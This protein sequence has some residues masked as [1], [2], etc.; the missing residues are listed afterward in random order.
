M[1]GGKETPRQKMIGMMYLVLTALLALN[2]SK[3]ILDAFVIINDGLESTKVTFK[4]KISDQ[5][6]RFEASFNENQTKY[7]DNWEKAKEVRQLSDDLRSEER[8][9][10]K[11]CRSRW[12]RDDE[13]KKRK[14][15]GEE[16][17]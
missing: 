7:R 10:G 9:V 17:S 3:E 6:A 2:V 14:R 8:R 15:K 1:A 5:Y 4:E 11:E 16:R 12:S 13:K